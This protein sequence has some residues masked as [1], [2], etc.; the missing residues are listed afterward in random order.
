MSRSELD[1]VLERQITHT[2][3]HTHIY[4]YIYAYA[5]NSMKILRGSRVRFWNSFNNIQ[6]LCLNCAEVHYFGSLIYFRLLYPVI[7]HKP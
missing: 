1:D 3:T 4:I 5:Y 2:H 7:T 6:A